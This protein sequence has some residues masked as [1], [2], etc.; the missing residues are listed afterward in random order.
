VL[1]A[2]SPLAGIPTGLRYEG[3]GG[4]RAEVSLINTPSLSL[5][6]EV[7][8]AQIGYVGRGSRGAGGP[9]QSPSDGRGVEVTMQSSSRLGQ[10]D[11]C[12]G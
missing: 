10:H 3:H 6:L 4:R 1:L 11:R 7:E 5:V 12:L 8:L 9:T 2:R